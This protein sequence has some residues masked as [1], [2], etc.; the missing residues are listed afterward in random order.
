[1]K[2]G[3]ASRQGVPRGGVISPLIA[4]LYTN[5][6]LTFWRQT[7]SGEAWKAHVINYADGFV[8]PADAFQ[9]ISPLRG[10]GPADAFQDISPLRGLIVSR[11][12]NFLVRRRKVPTRYGP[13]SLEYRG[14]AIADGKA[15]CREPAAKPAGKP[16]AGNPRVRFDDRG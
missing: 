12:R 8:S 7:G 9:D 16:G 10:L 15:S 1:M 13:Y 3:K 2:G 6:F 11:V 4:N 5:R 14:R